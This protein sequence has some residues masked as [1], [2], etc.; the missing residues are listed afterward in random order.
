MIL[1]WRWSC[2]IQIMDKTFEHHTR[3]ISPCEGIAAQHRDS[4]AI[5][6]TNRPELHAEL[7]STHLLLEWMIFCHAERR[8]N[9]TTTPLW[10]G[11]RD[12]KRRLVSYSLINCMR[13]LCTNWMPDG[14]CR[15]M[16]HNAAHFWLTGSAPCMK[17]YSK[18]SL[19][20]LERWRHR[21]LDTL[22]NWEK[23][24]EQINYLKANAPI[25]KEG[26]NQFY[27]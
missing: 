20:G 7:C 14:Q 24:A 19:F 2:C 4:P 15:W 5:K 21:S 13:D 23:V 8:Q 10:T 22:Q 16:L 12:G 26:K 11:R 25:E 6:M 3:R 17:V 1:Y 27:P 9:K 18:L